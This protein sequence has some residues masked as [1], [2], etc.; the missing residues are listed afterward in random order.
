LIGGTLAGDVI[1]VNPV[2]SKTGTVQVQINNEPIVTISGSAFTQIAVYAQDGADNVQIAG[3]ITRTA[4]LFGEGGNDRLKGGGGANFLAGG[5]GNDILTAD[6]SSGFSVLVGGRGIDQLNGNGSGDLL[7]GGQLDFEDPTNCDNDP[8]LCD[9]LHAWTGTPGQSY[10]SRAAAV[11]AI[12][13][14]HVLNDSAVDTLNGGSGL[15]LFYIS[16]GDILK[17]NQKGETVVTV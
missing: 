15:D 7:I 14:G 16:A 3:T 6:K 12:L 13:S 10:S 8:K 2:S 11:D 17:G 1:I 4:F 9:L 5:D